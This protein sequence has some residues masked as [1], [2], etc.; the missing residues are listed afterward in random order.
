[1]AADDIQLKYGNGYDHN[2]V[3]NDHDGAGLKKA[4]MVIGAVSGIVMEV[5]TDEPAV[6]LYGG[7]F[8]LSENTVGVAQKMISERPFV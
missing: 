5:F 3:L 1:L 8:I 4:A 7:N 2:F 6:Q